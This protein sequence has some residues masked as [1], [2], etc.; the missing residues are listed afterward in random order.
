[1]GNFLGSIS[2]LCCFSKESR[3]DRNLRHSFFK[4]KVI[5]EQDFNEM[6][7]N[8]NEIVKNENEIVKNKIVK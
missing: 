6:V 7:E 4:K 5:V 1:M 8:E 3:L 2:N